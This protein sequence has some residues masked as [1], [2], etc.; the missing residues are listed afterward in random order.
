MATQLDEILSKKQ[1]EQDGNTQK[2]WHESNLTLPLYV[3]L[4]LQPHPTP[5][6]IPSLIVL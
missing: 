3:D 5:D 6:T 4:S 1:K 2:G